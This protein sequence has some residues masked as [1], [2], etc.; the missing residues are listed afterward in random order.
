[1]NEEEAKKQIDADKASINGV[2]L[3]TACRAK[4]IIDAIDDRPKV[5]LPREV[6][7]ELDD[8]QAEDIDLLGYLH[9]VIDSEE[10]RVTRVWMLHDRE[11]RIGILADAYRYGWEA[12]KEKLYNVKVTHVPLYYWKKPD[13]SVGIDDLTVATADDDTNDFE[14]T[15]AEIEHYGLQDCEKVLEVTDDD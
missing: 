12:E 7:E 1:M 14:F 8:Y 5:K 10:L 15:E 2:K 6:G 13:G 3:I 4:D 11:H 9:D